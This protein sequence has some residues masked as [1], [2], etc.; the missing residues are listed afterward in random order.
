MPAI[1]AWL[2]VNI[3]TGGITFVPRVKTKNQSMKK[4]YAAIVSVTCMLTVTNVPAQ[5]QKNWYIIGG[6]ISHLNVD[7]QKD[8]TVFNFDLT[9]RVAWFIQDNLAVGLSILAGVSTSK[10]NST[11]STSFRY[12]IGPVAR[13]YITGNALNS[14]RKTRWFADLNIGFSGANT[15]ITG[16]SSISTNGIGTGLGPGIAYFI[17]QNIALE[18]LAKYNL[19]AGFGNSTTVNSLSLEIGFQVHLPRAKLRSMKNNDIK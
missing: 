19:S 4:F 12:G 17:N 14:V 7:F 2:L 5:T 15:K 1:T 10:T 11:T 16:E 18:A 8:N 13:Y 6:N 9:P 3:A